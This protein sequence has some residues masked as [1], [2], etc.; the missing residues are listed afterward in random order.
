MFKKVGILAVIGALSISG[1]TTTKE[2]FQKNPSGQSNSSL[3]RAYLN[4]SDPEFYVGITQ[5]LTARGIH[6]SQCKAIVDRQNTAIAA[7][8]IVGVAVAACASSSNCRDGFSGS[9]GYSYGDVAWDQFYDGRFQ[10]VWR[11]REENTG[12]FTYDYKCAGKPKSDYRWPSKSRF[13]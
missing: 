8:A 13:I 3:C 1:C 11:C 6:P 4:S 9:G 2:D 12:R 10:L 5:E 7:A